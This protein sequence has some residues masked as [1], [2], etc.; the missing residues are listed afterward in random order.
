MQGDLTTYVNS[1]MNE[2]NDLGSDLYEAMMDLDK[3]GVNDAIKKLKKV[4]N[5]IQRSYYEEL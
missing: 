2:F 3:P 5:D 1:A 4:L